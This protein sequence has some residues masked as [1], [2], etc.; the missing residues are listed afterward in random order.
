[1]EGFPQKSKKN[2]KHPTLPT[3]YNTASHVL[4]TEPWLSLQVSLCA[5]LILP[6]GSESF[7]GGVRGL[8]L[9]LAKN[10]CIIRSHCCWILAL[11]TLVMTCLFLY[12][13]KPQHNMGHMHS[14]VP[15][16]NFYDSFL[17][18]RFTIT[19]SYT[20]IIIPSQCVLLF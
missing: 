8:H 18:Q 14:L 4:N 11:L 17:E 1:M 13:C 2:K 16:C 5:S 7:S 6:H 9:F 3:Y 19:Q 10:I 12:S 20:A 15:K